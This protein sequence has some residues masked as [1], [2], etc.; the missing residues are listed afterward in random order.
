VACH[1]RPL[2]EEEE[3]EEEEEQWSV[4]KYIIR[5]LKFVLLTKC[6]L[7][8]QIDKNDKGGPCS[9]YGERISAY[10]VLVGKVRERITWKTRTYMGG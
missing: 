10:R 7:G 9:T 1:G 2:Q 3:E 8:G 5:S 6:Y 4:E